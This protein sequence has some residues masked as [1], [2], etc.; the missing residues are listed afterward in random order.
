M[1][2][3]R[4]IL[5]SVMACVLCAG[6][7]CAAEGDVVLKEGKAFRMD[8]GRETLLKDCELKQAE[9]EAGTWSWVLVDPAQSEDMKGA[10]GGVYLFRG[11]EARPAGF[12]PVKEEAS[13]CRLFFSP[14]GEKLV[15]SWGMEY[16]QHL[17]YYELDGG[18]GFVRKASFD[19]AGPAFWVDPH[20]FAITAVDAAKGL[21]AAGKF[22]LWW[23]SV[24]LYD[25][26]EKERIVIKEATATRTYVVNG[27][28]GGKGTL[29]VFESSV[30]DPGD[31]ADESKVKDEELSVPIPAAG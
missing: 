20:R 3:V 1:K 28:D 11:K 15:L 10:E 12:L 9:T 21:R 19:A 6:A 26:V 2:L 17:G 13:S 16:I 25:S 7:A 27:V 18:K 29:E 30:K 4:R 5:G 8:S 31:W 22:D 23:S 14:S 24:V